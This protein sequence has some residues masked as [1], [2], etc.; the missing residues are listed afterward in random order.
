MA[1]WYGQIGFAENQETDLDEWTEVITDISYPGD[2]LFNNRSLESGN[3]INSTINI[4]YKISFLAD[5]YARNN[6]HKIRYATFMGSKWRVTNV[7]VQ[8][9]RMTLTLGGLY[10]E[11]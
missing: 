5:P 1:K 2:V 4:S 9:P 7:E 8:Y 6:F 3:E 10:N 11:E